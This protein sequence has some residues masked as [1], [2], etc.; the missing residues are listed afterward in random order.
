M[1]AR[2]AAVIAAAEAVVLDP[3]PAALRELRQALC[4]EPISSFH[5]DK[6]RP[7]TLMLEDGRGGHAISRL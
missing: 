4:A 7:V 3:T 5:V 2:L 1:D 6:R